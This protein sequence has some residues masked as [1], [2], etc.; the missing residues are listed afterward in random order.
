M[1]D[2][3]RS[4]RREV[5]AG[6]VLIIL[7]TTYLATHPS[8]A[9][10]YVMTISANQYVILGLAASAQFFAVVLRGIDLSVGARDGADQLSRFLFAGRLCLGH[11]LRYGGRRGRRCALRVA[12]WRHH[13]F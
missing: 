13:R 6:V 5:V 7:L 1:L 12:Q 3:V 10:T 2:Y 9:S 4:N 8:G 11:S